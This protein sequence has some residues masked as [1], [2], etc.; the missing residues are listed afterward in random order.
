MRLSLFALL[1][2][3][4]LAQAGPFQVELLGGTSNPSIE[5]LGDFTFAASD[6]GAIVSFTPSHSGP[7]AYD[8]PLWNGTDSNDV[9]FTV[10][11]DVSLKITNSSGVSGVVDVEGHVNLSWIHKWDGLYL[12]PEAFFG[13]NPQRVTVG[14]TNYAVQVLDNTDSFFET[15]T[16]TVQVS[17]STPEPGTLALAVIGLVPF[18]RL[19]RVGA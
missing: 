2:A 16:G 17:A 5:G 6:H 11:F 15:A 1:L 12:S 18:V 8:D 14:G 19:R 10:P 13:G 7:A 4:N 9:L 3:T